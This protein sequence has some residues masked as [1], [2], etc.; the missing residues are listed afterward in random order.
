MTSGP[1]S[2]VKS[3]LSRIRPARVQEDQEVGG[4][5]REDNSQWWAAAS[6]ASDVAA[7]HTYSRGLASRRLVRSANAFAGALASRMD[8]AAVVAGDAPLVRT[9]GA[10]EKRAA[11]D[12][13]RDARV[14]REPDLAL[15]LA[16]RVTA[17]DPGS[18][19]AWMYLAGVQRSRDELVAAARAEE[20][21]T[22]RD[23]LAAATAAGLDSLAAAIGAAGVPVDDHASEGA[24]VRLAETLERRALVTGGL[25][26][27]GA[28]DVARAHRDLAQASWDSRWTAAQVLAVRP[29]ELPELRE[30]ATGRRLLVVLD[31]ADPAA[32]AD[33]LPA[34]GI[35]VRFRDVEPAADVA[36]IHVAEPGDETGWDVP[37]EVRWV[38]SADE[39][40]WHDA[41]IHRID[42]AAQPTLV[43]AGL[44]DPLATVAGRRHGASTP[45]A[46]VRTL[47]A[48][49][50]GAGLD[51]LLPAAIDT[52][53]EDLAAW[54]AERGIT[55]APGL[56]RLGGGA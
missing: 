41:L 20:R 54:L 45:A 37:V 2:L 52:L 19:L 32:V 35:V 15:A 10:R 46:I 44:R 55:P 26:A 27:A 34:A 50:L 24:V 17:A 21:G 23:G 31:G 56:V 22:G 29:A 16:E 3:A 12:L 6:L 13:V 47:D 4:R 7:E 8:S 38:V 36:V 43:G 9:G 42:P 39:D 33:A 25:P 48:L 30:L 14:A 53:P 51:V 1:R 11:L 40:A 5:H 49:G 18:L 28:L